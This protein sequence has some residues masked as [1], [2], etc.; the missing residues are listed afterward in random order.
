MQVILSGS[1]PECVSFLDYGV[2]NIKLWLEFA[3][4]LGA[5]RQM[6]MKVYRMLEWYYFGL[7]SAEIKAQGY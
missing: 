4:W 5:P 7:E 1:I 3:R 6:Q 2:N